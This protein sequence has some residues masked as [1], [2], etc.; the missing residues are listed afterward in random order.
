MHPA[1][2]HVTFT[3]SKR[4]PVGLQKQ[5]Q[6]NVYAARAVWLLMGLLTAV[7]V[8]FQ[9]ARIVDDGRGGDFEQ[10]A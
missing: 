7:R 10:V 8:Q 6:E 4:L 3:Q 2:R 1:G 9:P 5:I